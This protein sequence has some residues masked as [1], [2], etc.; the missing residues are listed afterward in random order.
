MY[1]TPFV[2]A[3]NLNRCQV[4][5]D[6]TMVRA[7]QSYDAGP[8]PTTLIFQQDSDLPFQV[9]ESADEVVARIHE[10]KQK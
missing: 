6:L 10:A 3:T 9:E 2:D 4:F 8:K 5:L 7:V 1:L